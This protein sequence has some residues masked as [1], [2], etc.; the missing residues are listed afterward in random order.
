MKATPQSN[1]L[2]TLRKTR[3]P[4]LLSGEFSVTCAL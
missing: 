4:K 2:A 1:T 3:M